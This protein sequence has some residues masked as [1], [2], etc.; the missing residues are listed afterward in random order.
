MARRTG[1]GQTPVVRAFVIP[2]LLAAGLSG[3]GSGGTTGGEASC[4]AL[5][6][7]A[8]HRYSGHGDLM[9]E[10]ATTGHTA[11][12]VAPGCDD[13]NGAAPHR[14]VD[15]QELADVPMDRAVLVEGTIYVRTDTPLP[16]ETRTWFEQPTCRTEG[17][18]ELRGTWLSVRGPHEP[19]FDGDLR[20][21]YRLEMHV[22]TG[23]PDYARTTVTVRATADTDPLLGR[24][25][26]KTSLWEGGD[27]IAQV[28]C[29][30]DRFV[31]SALA[32]TP[33]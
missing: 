18:F 4:A 7:F 31:A 5:L 17:S 13:G 15:V 24:K 14:T 27:V 22:R 11:S 6:D 33:G 28:T 10:P 12:G 23:P 1:M 29:Q 21:P 32:S 9:R 19:R 20:P 25:D 2:L 8:G 26:V 3:C 30:D 16:E